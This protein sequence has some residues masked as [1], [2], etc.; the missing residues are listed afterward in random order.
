MEWKGPPTTGN[1][2]QSWRFSEEKRAPVPETAVETQLGLG[3]VRSGSGISINRGFVTVLFFLLL[4]P[5]RNA[6]RRL[7]I[8]AFPFQL[9]KFGGIF[10]FAVLFSFEKGLSR[11]FIPPTE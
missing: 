5:S 6:W 3:S 2:S 4:K 9:W 1:P 11:D 7:R 8:G 10:N